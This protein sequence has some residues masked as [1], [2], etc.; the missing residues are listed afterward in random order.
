MT[1]DPPTGETTPGPYIGPRPFRASD[2]A[3]FFGRDRE[4]RYARKLWQADRVLILHGPIATGKTSLL[5]AGVLP[6]VAAEESV[7]VLPVGRLLHQAAAP[8]AVQPPHNPYVSTLLS[9]WSRGPVPPPGTTISEA[10]RGHP[11]PAGDEPPSLLAVIDQFEELFTAFPAY[12]AEREDLID[13][14][15]QALRD[16]SALKLLIVVRDDH[17]GTLAAYEER[18]SP[19]PV[20]HLRLDALTRDAALRAVTGPAGVYGVTYADGVA[21]RLVEELA[22]TTYTDALGGATTVTSD[23]VEPMNLQLTCAALW[24]RLPGGVTEIDAEQVRA[25]GDLGAALDEFYD[26]AVAEVAAAHHISEEELR[27]WLEREFLTERGTRGTAYRGIESTARMPNAVADDL[28]T[29]QVLTEEHRA[30]AT[31]YQIGQDQLARAVR[32]AN[33]RWR[34]ARLASEAGVD[35]GP[36][37]VALPPSASTAVGPAGTVRPR[38]AAYMAA[39]EAALGEGDVASAR[40]YADTA[41]DAYRAAGET[42]RLGQALALQGDIARVAGDITGAQTLLRSAL[43]EFDVLEDT[44]AV[45]RLLT[46]LAALRM[47]AGDHRGAVDLAEQAISR[48][49][50]D[51]ATLVEL[52]GAYWLDGRLTA[53][54]ATFGQAIAINWRSARAWSGRGQVRAEMELYE[55]AAADLDRALA[56]GLPDHDLQGAHSARALAYAGAGDADGAAAELVV[57]RGLGGADRPLTLLRTARVAALSGDVEAARRALDRA[58]TVGPPLDPAHATQ[59]DRLARVLGLPRTP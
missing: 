19:D 21:E 42:R 32:R 56:L 39:A 53:A 11:L 52:A 4:A 8:I 55:A 18:L 43:A 35:L 51:P 47:Q 15:A 31:W 12:A 58:R 33:G 24:S 46:S 57:A 17:L 13:Q 34:A 23:R 9:A 27:N 37:D 49:P 25:A 14:L 26:R 20:P 1:G 10:L 44:H 36:A 29:R 30:S 3:L 38:P 7:E 41:A 59:A 5:N 40:Q 16:V 2:A 48:A 45:A 54:E 28:V 6:L 50:G 22:T